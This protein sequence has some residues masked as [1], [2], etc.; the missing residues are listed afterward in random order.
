MNIIRRRNPAHIYASINENNDTV[1]FDIDKLHSQEIDEV[2]TI[3][4]LLDDDINDDLYNYIKEHYYINGSR[5]EL[6]LN[7][8]TIQ[9]STDKALDSVDK[10]FVIHCDEFNPEY[11]FNITG[12][13]KWSIRYEDNFS[14]IIE[15][16]STSVKLN[17]YDNI[18]CDNTTKN[19]AFSLLR[20]NPKLTGNIK[21][22]V[23]DDTLYL[24]TFKY[25]TASALSNIQYCHKLASNTGD[26]AA[27]IFRVFG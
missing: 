20:T 7:D 12:T 24:D 11:E 9:I 13:I 23:S 5:F 19:A 4:L 17:S 15:H 3:T 16:L 22:V 21:L 10:I 8:N 2:V 27:D 14:I 25:K 26:Y 1:I 6:L 18:G